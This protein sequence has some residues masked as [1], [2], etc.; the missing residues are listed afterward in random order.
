MIAKLASSLV[1]HGT[2]FQYHSE[3]I[4][5]LEHDGVDFYK[6]L[7]ITPKDGRAIIEY[8]PVISEYRIPYFPTVNALDVF[9]N[10]ISK[11]KGRT[12]KMMLT[13]LGVPTY[14]ESTINQYFTISMNVEM[15]E[16]TDFEYFVTNL[17]TIYVEFQS[18]AELVIKNASKAILARALN[19]ELAKAA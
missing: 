7:A 2:I 13:F 10:S 3:S 17:W 15:S 16:N 6:T 19:K 1:N 8:T 9:E 18:L 5:L 12:G 4:F 14:D 11:L